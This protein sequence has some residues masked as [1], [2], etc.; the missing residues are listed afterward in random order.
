MC[1]QIAF[2]MFIVFPFLKIWHHF[3]LTAKREIPKNGHIWTVSPLL[4][5]QTDLSLLSGFQVCRSPD[6]K[7]NSKLTL[8]IYICYF[9]T[10]FIITSMCN[11][12]DLKRRN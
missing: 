8:K 11:F 7:V 9:S 1:T 3:F 2:S 12:A 5:F 6:Q 4:C 10:I